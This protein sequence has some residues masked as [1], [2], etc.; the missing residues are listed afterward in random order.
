MTEQLQTITKQCCQASPAKYDDLSVLFL[1]CTLS[2][3][4]ILSH[5]EG[6]IKVAQR[7]FETNGVATKI[8]RPV[9]YD[10]AAGL[11]LDMAKT[12]EWEKDDWPQIQKRSRRLR[13]PHRLHVGLAGGEEFGVQPHARKDV[14]LHPSVQ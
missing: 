2:R 9:D 14:W 11:G 13:H 10:I 3:N 1:N 7:I 6:L 4:P 8:I 5:T 12:D